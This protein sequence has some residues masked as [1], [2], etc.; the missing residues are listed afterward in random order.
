VT[1]V[2]HKTVG[3]RVA[4][5]VF[6]D[7]AGWL[8]MPLALGM[9]WAELRLLAWVVREVPV[10]DEPMKLPPRLGGKGKAPNK[11]AGRPPLPVSPR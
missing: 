4:D 11:P 1:G 7:L 9:L 5:V 6:H 2:L 10:A 3:S 8:M